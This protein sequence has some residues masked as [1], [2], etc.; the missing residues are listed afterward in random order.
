MTVAP[1][2]PQGPETRDRD[3]LRR[4]VLRI[5]WDDATTPSVLVPVGD[6]FG[7][8][9]ARTVNFASAP[10][11]MSPEDGRAFNSFFHMRSRAVPASN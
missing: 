7:V 3:Y 4:L 8:G 5:Y 1:R 2:N 6:F 9:H 10:L 11:Q